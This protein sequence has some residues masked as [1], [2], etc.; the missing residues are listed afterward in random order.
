MHA[1]HR[2]PLMA[3][4]R[5]LLPLPGTMQAA[6]T[7]CWVYVTSDSQPAQDIFL[8]HIRE[9]QPEVHVTGAVGTPMH[10]DLSAFD[11]ND[12]ASHL[13]SYVDWELLR[14]MDHL[15][16]SRSGFGETAAW[17]SLIPAE[18]MSEAATND[19]FSLD[20]YDSVIG[21]PAGVHP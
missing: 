14:R 7:P 20:A 1:A 11:A 8:Q 6:P 4:L 5:P 10:V 3:C 15:V 17:T 9:Q 12:T 13:K 18:R 16:V 19:T 21:M 2:S